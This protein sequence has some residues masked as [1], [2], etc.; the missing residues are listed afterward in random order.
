MNLLLFIRK[1]KYT[2][3][4]LDRNYNFSDE[5]EFGNAGAGTFSSFFF[6]V[7]SRVH[8]EAVVHIGKF[9]FSL[10]LGCFPLP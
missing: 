1:R 2:A 7:A 10:L 5:W 9:L 4:E 8:T 6:P 3:S